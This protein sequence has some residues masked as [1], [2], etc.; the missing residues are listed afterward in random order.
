MH[1][2]PW[3]EY[4]KKNRNSYQL[5]SD[6]S[7]NILVIG[8]G[9]AGIVTAYEILEKTNKSVTVV[10]ANT[11]GSGASGNNAG[12]L[13]SEIELSFSELIARFGQT[14][15]EHVVKSYDSGWDVLEDI[16]KKV[17]IIGN[18][19]PVNDVWNGYTDPKQIEYYLSLKTASQPKMLIADTYSER[20]ELVKKY[21]QFIEVMPHKTILDYLETNNQQFIAAE[22]GGKAGF[23]SSIQACEDLIAYFTKNYSDRFSLFEN[24]RIL[25]LTDKKIAK[26]ATNYDIKF[27]TVVL[28]TNG[29]NSIHHNGKLLTDVTGVVDFMIGNQ[30]SLNSHSSPK[31][32]V[33]VDNT[34]NATTSTYMYLSRRDI[35]SNELTA[36]GG[37]VEKELP[38]EQNYLDQ[39]VP[40]EEEKHAFATLKKLTQQNY[41]H[42]KDS[43]DFAWSSVQGYTKTGLRIIGTDKQI[44]W[45]MYNIGCNGIGNIPCMFGARKVAKLLNNETFEPSAFDPQ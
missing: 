25:T 17:G 42:Y 38:A 5:T 3:I 29:F 43:P 12:W 44:P 11:V 20:D 32:M 33:Y 8:A 45:L 26:T 9:I 13:T 23:M 15:A 21:Q 35:G 16:T 7:T 19:I 31:G 40:V 14:Q 41:R 1:N 22:R 27:D 2:S 36:I 4:L 10:E 28:C 24:T 39:K 30:E 6:I 34:I 37:G 18:Y